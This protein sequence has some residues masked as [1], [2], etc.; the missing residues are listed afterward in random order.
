MK[1]CYIVNGICT[2]ILFCIT[3][4]LGRVTWMRYTV[5]KLVTGRVNLEIGNCLFIP[6]LPYAIAWQ[7]GRKFQPSKE[8]K[9]WQSSYLTFLLH[10]KLR[11]NCEVTK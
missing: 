4:E 8:Q 1:R 3:F 5:I 10:V 11:E 2:V 6:R 9:T 7:L